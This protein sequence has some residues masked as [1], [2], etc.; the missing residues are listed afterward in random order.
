MESKLMEN[1]GKRHLSK[2]QVESG[3]WLQPLKNLEVVL[4]RSCLNI[5]VIRRLN[6]NRQIDKKYLLM[7]CLRIPNTSLALDWQK[8]L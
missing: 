5:D 8:Q 7:F 1:P 2:W 3:E 4:D 6:G